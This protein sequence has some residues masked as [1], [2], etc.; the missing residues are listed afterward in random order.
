MVMI[1]EMCRYHDLQ[2]LIFLSVSLLASPT[3]KNHIC[4]SLINA[5]TKV[6]EDSAE[7]EGSKHFIKMFPFI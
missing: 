5:Q 1:Y 6:R 4:E 7:S 3:F 2:K